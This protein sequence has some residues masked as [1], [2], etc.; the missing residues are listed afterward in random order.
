M[1]D[2]TV[3]QHRWLI[4]AFFG[5]LATVV[6]WIMCPLALWGARERRQTKPEGTK[7]S[8]YE[9][10]RVFPWILTLS[11]LGFIAYQ[12]IHTIYLALYPPN[13]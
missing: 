5:G 3:L 10:L 6:G 1:F 9:T 12:I 2:Y 13:Y 11:I 7:F 8:W 4:L